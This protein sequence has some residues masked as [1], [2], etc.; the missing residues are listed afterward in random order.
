MKRRNFLKILGIGAVA[1]AL[2]ASAC[3]VKPPEEVVGSLIVDKEDK[4]HHHLKKFTL[5]LF[6]NIVDADGNGDELNYWGYERQYIDINF[7]LTNVAE[8]EMSNQNQIKFPAIKGYPFGLDPLIAMSLGIYDGK[9]LMFFQQLNKKTK[10]YDGD[11]LSF[12]E[13]SITITLL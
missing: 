8:G 9:N 6:S 7:D 12:N 11:V 1:T 10:L 4:T 13:G 5:A 3:Q 2:P